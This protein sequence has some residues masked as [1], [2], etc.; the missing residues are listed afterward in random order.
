MQKH[1]AVLFCKQYSIHATCVL[2]W[3]WGFVSFACIDFRMH[4]CMRACMSACVRACVRRSKLYVCVSVYVLYVIMHVKLHRSLYNNYWSFA[5]QRCQSMIIYY[6]SVL[7]IHLNV[8]LNHHRTARR[9]DSTI[10]YR[11]ECLSHS[12]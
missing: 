3:W 5:E 11:S 4:A 1:N 7:I 6:Y 2:A 9:Y 10:I 8:L 12:E